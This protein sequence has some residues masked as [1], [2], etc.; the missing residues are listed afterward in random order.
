MQS[1]YKYGLYPQIYIFVT[2]ICIITLLFACYFFIVRDL[3]SYEEAGQA[4]DL[5]IT[6]FVYEKV[7]SGERFVRRYTK[8]FPQEQFFGWDEAKPFRKSNT[9]LMH[10]LLYCTEK[11][12]QNGIVLPEHTFYVDN[13]YAYKPLPY[14]RK[15]YYM[16]IDLYRYFIGREDQ[17]VSRNNIVKRY[18]QQIRV[19]KEM[20]LSCSGENMTMLPRNLQKYM[21]HNLS[22]IMVLT[23]MFTTAGKDEAETRKI[24]LEELW[25][26][27]RE[28]DIRPDRYL[29]HRAYP[30]LI[31][32]MS[33]SLQGVVT[34][35]GY[36]FFRRKLKCS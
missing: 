32:W 26:F 34:S 4:A 29:R 8:N 10:S 15:L 1:Y 33:F 25:P 18:L 17:S 14:M 27:I 31:S 16:D 11:L 12:R 24:A 21:K 13:I 9:L 30:A 2:L 20:I 5:Y 28:K 23:L 36:R 22:V 19:M 6:N 7:F 3:R 35:I